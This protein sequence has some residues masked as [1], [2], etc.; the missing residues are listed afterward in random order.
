MPSNLKLSDLLRELANTDL[1]NSAA[2]GIPS[3]HPLCGRNSCVPGGEEVERQW[4][5]GRT[6]AISYVAPSAGALQPDCIWLTTENCARASAAAVGSHE[7]L[8]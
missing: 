3:D 4:W 6:L 1:V 7:G 5:R 8:R 2:T